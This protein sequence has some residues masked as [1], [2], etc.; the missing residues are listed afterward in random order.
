MKL[1]LIQILLTAI[2]TSCASDYELGDYSK[3]ALPVILTAA[4]IVE[5]S[6]QHR[7]N[8]NKSKCEK[9]G[10]EQTNE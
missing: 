3:A 4:E 7:C 1:L 8:I 5:N 2:L 9:Y 10:L 6:R